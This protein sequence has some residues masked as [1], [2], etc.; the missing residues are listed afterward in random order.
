MATLS[1]SGAWGDAAADPVPLRG[2]GEAPQS[3]TRTEGTQADAEYGFGTRC[4]FLTTGS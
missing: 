3:T 4:I 2:R 1:L